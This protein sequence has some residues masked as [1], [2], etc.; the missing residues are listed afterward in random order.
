MHSKLHNGCRWQ[1]PFSLMPCRC[2]SLCSLSNVT[3]FASSYCSKISFN[4]DFNV[5]GWY[6]FWI[7]INSENSFNVHYGGCVQCARTT[8]C[9]N[10]YVFSRNHDSNVSVPNNK[11]RIKVFPEVVFSRRRIGVHVT[12]WQS[13]L[14]FFFC[15]YSISLNNIEHAKKELNQMLL[16]SS[17]LSHSIEITIITIICTSIIQMFSIKSFKWTKKK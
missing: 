4:L 15:R 13:L 10:T 1:D 12:S 9:A 16:T 17:M 8:R 2:I 5:V 3:L 14:C 6:I 11:Q 7:I